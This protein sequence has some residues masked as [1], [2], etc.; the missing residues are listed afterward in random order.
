MTVWSRCVGGPLLA[1]VLVSGVTRADDPIRDSEAH[2]A[3]SQPSVGRQ[4]RDARPPE[5]SSARPPSA[6]PIA[7]SIDRVVE[8]FIRERTPCRLAGEGVPCFPTT[9]EREALEFSV[10]DSLWGQEDDGPP[11]PPSGRWSD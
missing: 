8:K 2:S 3:A 1:G 4:A 9:I 5:G 6:R 11:T 7:E 10:D